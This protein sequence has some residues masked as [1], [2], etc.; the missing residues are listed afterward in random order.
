MTNRINTWPL[1]TWTTIL[2]FC[3]VCIGY[4]VRAQDLVDKVKEDTWSVEIGGN[5]VGSGYITFLPNTMT[6]YIIIKPNI[7]I[8]RTTGGIYSPAT[9]GFF[10]IGG[11]WAT[12]TDKSTDKSERRTGFFTGSQDIIC[13]PTTG[14]LNLEANSFS[15]T[16]KTKTTKTGSESKKLSM[17]AQTNDGPMQFKGVEVPPPD[18]PKSPKSLDKTSWT[19]TVLKVLTDK[20]KHHYIAH[21]TEFFTLTTPSDLDLPNLYE[22][23]GTGADFEVAGCVLLSAGNKMAAQI[24]ESGGTVL[25]VRG[26]FN[27]KKDKASLTGYDSDEASV[28]ITMTKQN[29][30]EE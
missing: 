3:C 4:V 30:E 24:E 1:V 9:V 29:N 7:I 5:V 12:D 16:V 2:I 10:L 27:P 8:N 22:L 28:S 6:G 25:Y 26:K 19:A 13:V 11:K 17:T 20:K 21:S 14:G 18:D 23:S 15:A